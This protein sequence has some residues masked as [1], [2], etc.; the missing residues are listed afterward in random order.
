MLPIESQRAPRV[1]H[2]TQGSRD[3]SRTATECHRKCAKEAKSTPSAM[4]MHSHSSPNGGQERRTG[5]RSTVRGHEPA[6]A[7]SG[8]WQATWWPGAELGQRRLDGPA[9]LLRLPAPGVEA[10]GRAAG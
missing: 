10:A 3:R 5:E 9:D 4:A 7:F 6:G 2:V 1:P 8:K